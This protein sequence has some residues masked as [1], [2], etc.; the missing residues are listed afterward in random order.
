MSYGQVEGFF[1]DTCILLPHPLESMTK[2][3]SD[4][5]EE[6]SKQCMISS[7]VKQEGL[8]LIQEAHDIIIKHVH[9]KLNPYLEKE[10]VKEVSNR[11]GKVFADF[12]AQQRDE[13]RKLPSHQRSNVRN[14]MLGAVENYVASQLHSLDDGEKMPINIFLPAIAA[15]LAV[16]KHELEAPFKGMRPIEIQPSDS[17]YSAIAVGGVQ[18]PDDVKH[19]NSNDIKH[20]ASAQEYQFRQNKWVIFVT[21]DASEI[22]N[23]EKDLEEMFLRCSRPEWAVDH[24]RDM[25]KRKPPLEYIYDIKNYT[26]KQKRVVDAIEKTI[27][28]KRR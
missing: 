23:K 28:A 24:Q 6:T 14:E 22:L 11:D 27:G 12:F 13:L 4:F 21:T 8:T 25:T 10:G 9:S 17:I 7:S 20:L 1:L 5:L 3:C 18:N 16:Q 2:A 15:E 26:P 19:L